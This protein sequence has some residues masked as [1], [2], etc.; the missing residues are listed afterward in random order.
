MIGRQQFQRTNVLLY[1]RSTGRMLSSA[2]VLAA[3]S[4]AHY[5]FAPSREGHPEGVCAGGV[6]S[7]C[8]QVHL[9]TQYY[10]CVCMRVYV[11]D[12]GSWR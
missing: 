2:A 12:F 7:Q 4:A 10:R 1:S 8:I 3:T 5:E 6:Q 9:V 11:C